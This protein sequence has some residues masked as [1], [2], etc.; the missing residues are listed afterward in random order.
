MSC[1]CCQRHILLLLCEFV[2]VETGTGLYTDTFVMRAT[3]GYGDIRSLGI[4]EWITLLI[5]QSSL[6]Y[7][8][9]VFVSSA[10]GTTEVVYA[11]MRRRCVSGAYSCC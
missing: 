2:Y 7:L 9:A 5:I 1:H 4:F 3:A 11:S 8:T 10:V 6:V